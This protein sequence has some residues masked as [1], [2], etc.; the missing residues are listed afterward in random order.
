MYFFTEHPRIS[1][2][3]VIRGL[4]LGLVCILISWSGLLSPI[5]QWNLNLFLK[6]MCTWNPVG[7][8]KCACAWRQRI[9]NICMLDPVILSFQLSQG[10]SGHA[11]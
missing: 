3:H 7:Y 5:E 1:R 6:H 2:E 10:I 8:V 9:F 4:S 11:F